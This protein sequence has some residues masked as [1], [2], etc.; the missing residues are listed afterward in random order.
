MILVTIKPGTE[1]PVGRAAGVIY[2][3]V[4]DIYPIVGRYT[5]HPEERGP[6]QWGEMRHTLIAL[7]RRISPEKWPEKS[8]ARAPLPVSMWEDWHVI[9]DATNNTPELIDQGRISV[10]IFIKSGRSV[11]SCGGNFILARVVKIEDGTER[12]YMEVEYRP[13]A[14][15]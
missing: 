8:R 7:V 1:P 13:L 4:D 5:T 14:G 2:V 3:G 9:C 6:A 12:P 11:E 10:T 15:M